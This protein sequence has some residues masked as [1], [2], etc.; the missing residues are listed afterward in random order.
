MTDSKPRRDLRRFAACLSALLLLTLLLTGA[1]A[2]PVPESDLTAQDRAELEK[3]EDYLNG[4]TTFSA[5]FDQVDSNGARATGNVYV[6]KPGNLRF[7]YDPPVPILIVATG[8]FLIHYDRSLKSATYLNQA[9]TPA[10][11]LTT[12]EIELNGDV[13]PLRLFRRDGLLH[14]TLVR[15]DKPDEGAVTLS[16]AENPMTLEEWT[17]VDPRGIITRVVLKNV[18]IGGKVDPKLF[19][20]DEPTWNEREYPGQR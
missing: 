19:Q 16:F 8:R 3:V 17:V 12:P 14:V 10:W 13:T 2:A 6:S 5:R 15:T 1:G 9:A 11:F 4:I 7:E 18:L 20:F